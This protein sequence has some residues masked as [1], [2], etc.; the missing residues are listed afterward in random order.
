MNHGR[1]KIQLFNS[2]KRMDSNMFK[3]TVGPILG[4]TTTDHARIF[5]RG[6]LQKDKLVFAGARYR[7]LDTE[8]WSTGTVIQLEPAKDMSTVIVFNGLHANTDY[9]YQAG[10]F[11]SPTQVVEESQLQWP[12]H[13]YRLRTRSTQTSMPRAYLAGS[14]RYLGMAAGIALAPHLGDRIF[15]SMSRLARQADPPISALLMTGDQV[16]I[17]DLNIFAPDRKL[18]DILRKYRVAFSQ[19]EIAR[20]MS[21]VPTYMTLDDHEIEDN[22]PANRRPW[23][24]FL[25]ANAMKAYELYQASHSPAYEQLADGQVSNQLEKYWYQFHEG[26]IEWFITDTRTCRNLSVGDRRILDAEQEQALC[27]WLIDSPARVK[28]VVSSVL[29]FPDQKRRD[30]DAWKGFAEQRLRLLETIREHQVKNVIFV[31]GD[32]HGSLTSRLRHS[33]DPH[34]EVHTIVSSPLCNSKWLTYATPSTFVLDQPLARTATGDYRHEL[35]GSVVSRDNF[36]HFVVEAGHIEVNYHDR[37][38]RL[39]QSTRILLR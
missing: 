34:F 30:E 36:A 16:Y 11:V 15:A 9:E 8:D 26:D 25:Y 1:Q 21:R 22:W 4:H 39:V 37:D 29:F 6:E 18:Q 33:A 13:T 12:S 38:G 20:L 35:I 17:D 14:C 28:F 19:P 23:D 2:K 32:V 5:L 27:T 3:P 31:A 7:P 10:W 24:N